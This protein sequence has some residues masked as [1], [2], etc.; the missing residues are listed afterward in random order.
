M[1]K[2]IYL[3]LFS[4]VFIFACDPQDNKQSADNE[5]LEMLEAEIKQE[6]EKI[7]NL[8][9]NEAEIDSLTE[10]IENLISDIE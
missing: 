6:E 10:E 7:E 3:L 8:E 1:K 2:S 4:A 5:E 9:A